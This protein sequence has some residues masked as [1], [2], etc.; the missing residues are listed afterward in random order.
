MRIEI[1]GRNTT[2]T[3][4]IRQHVAERFERVSRQV[5]EPADLE[6]EL[7]EERNPAIAD[8][9]IAEATLHLKGTTL[10][11]KEASP[12]LTHSVDLCAEKITR[13]VKRRLDKQRRSRRESSTRQPAA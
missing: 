8:G 6:V 1:K 7:M 3:D 10:R 4:A 2:V 13:Q 9:K 5:S 11:A 12:D